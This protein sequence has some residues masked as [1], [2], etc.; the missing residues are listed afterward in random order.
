MTGS[1]SLSVSQDKIKSNFDSVQEQTGLFAGKDGY[2]INVGEHT[3]LNGAVIASTA[4]TDKNKL[5]TGSLGWTDIGNKADFSSQHQS[6]SGGTGG[7]LGSTFMGNMGSL[8]LVGANN[9]GHDSSTTYSAVSGGE[10]TI[11]DKP[12]QQQDLATLSRDVEHASNALSPI[13]DK[14]KEQKRLRQAQLIGEIGNQSMDIIRTQ[15]AIEASKAAQ[16]QLTEE[17]RNMPGANPNAS[18]ED[19]Q[20]YIAVLQATDAYK[21]TMASY[22]TGSSLQQAA[23][24]VTAA[25]QGLAG[26]NLGQAL[27]GASA[28]YLAETIKKMTQGNEEA[29]IM[30]HAVLGAVSASVQAGNA[31]AGAAGAAVAAAGTE[32]IMQALYGTKDVSSLSET[33][34]QTVSALMTLAGGISGAVVGGDSA[35]TLAGAQSGKNATENNDMFSLPPGLMEYGQAATSLAQFGV[36]RGD[37]NEVI[38]EAQRAL[39]EGRGFEGPEPVKG[40]IQAWTIM[41]AGPLSAA[42]LSVGAAGMVLGAAI[43][44]ERMSVTN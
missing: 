19:R 40:L 4:S 20:K 41:M 17:Q 22:G 15:G 13:F 42:E 27:M 11:R 26:G 32:A 6:V 36:T 2:Q 23:Q 9:N 7:D 24:A 29:R 31:G 5:N 38:A 25:V 14:E 35:S 33:Q 3:Q 10:I 16:S 34:K 18:Y 37:S 30:A 39:V 8:L 43:S 28:P 21:K 1:A 44:G 12:K